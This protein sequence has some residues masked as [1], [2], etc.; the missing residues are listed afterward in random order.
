M[1]VSKS[2]GQDYVIFSSNTGSTEGLK[3]LK[4]AK[5]KYNLPIVTECMGISQIPII[6]K[7]ADVMRFMGY[8]LQ[9][10]YKK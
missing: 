7:Y 6:E 4:K 8:M 9:M 5:D 10:H 2:L 3:L 1:G